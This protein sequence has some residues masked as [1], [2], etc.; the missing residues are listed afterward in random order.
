MPSDQDQH[1]ELAAG[2]SGAD[3]SSRCKCR[4]WV[5]EARKAEG[6]KLSALKKILTFDRRPEV[7]SLDNGRSSAGDGGPGD[8]IQNKDLGK[9]HKAASV[10]DAAKVEE[11]LL[12]QK[13]GVDDRD[14]MSRLNPSDGRLGV[15]WVLRRFLGPRYNDDLIVKLKTASSKCICLDGKNKL[16]QQELL[17]M[18]AIEKKCEKLEN[19]KQKLKQEIVNLKRH[20]EMNMVELSEVLLYKQKI[21]ERARRDV[22]DKLEQVNLILQTQ[23]ASKE[24]SEQLIEYRNAS[25]RSDLELRNK[26][27]ESQLSKVR[28]FLNDSRSELEKYERLYLEE[29][30]GRKSLESELIEVG[31]WPRAAALGSAAPSV[32]ATDRSSRPP[33]VACDPSQAPHWCP[34]PGK[35][36]PEAFPAL[37]R[38]HPASLLR[39]AGADP[40]WLPEIRAG[41]PLVPKASAR[42]F[43]GLG[44][45][46][47]PASLRWFP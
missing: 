6:T 2:V 27:L 1:Q 21:E 15:T 36:L 44:L 24:L 26:D 31:A 17:S 25:M 16:L 37:A 46:R 29:L 20:M 42:G 14:K 33:V 28:I 13:H 10:G 34:R 11:M 9:M 5:P 39:I 19:K 45:G 8:L 12:L 23:I 22:E 4:C 47:T 18:K 32:P 41:S 40:Q 38:P 43:P 3:T 35:P 7:L 30:K